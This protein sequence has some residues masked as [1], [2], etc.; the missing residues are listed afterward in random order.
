MIARKLKMTRREAACCCMEMWEW[1]DDETTDGHIQG[2][3]ADD[4]D[5]ILGVPGFAAALESEEVE[6]LRVNSRGVSFPRWDRNNGETAKKRA[7]ETRKKQRQRGLAKG[8]L[9]RNKRDKRPA[10]VPG[11][12]G[13]ETESETEPEITSG[14]HQS[15]GPHS[16]PQTERRTGSGASRKHALDLTLEVLRDPIEFERWCRGEMTHPKGF[17]KS[18]DDRAFA[19]AARNK[20]LS[21]ASLTNPVGWF[22]DVLRHKRYDRV[23]AGNEVGT[24]RAPASDDPAI[25]ELNR[26]LEAKRRE[27]K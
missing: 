19:A 8:K 14:K 16:T 26:I 9:S 12:A 4:I 15:A 10:D 7:L 1:A 2:A 24:A 11:D 17:V 22:K 5:S 6:W 23:P 20:A 21:E 27:I 25:T 3:T 13:P 18:E